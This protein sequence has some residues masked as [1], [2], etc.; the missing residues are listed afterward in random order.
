MYLV[1]LGDFDNV[2]LGKIQD[3]LFSIYVCSLKIEN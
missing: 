3:F 2:K 1:I